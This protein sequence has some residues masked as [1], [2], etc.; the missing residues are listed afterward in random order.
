ME[1]IMDKIKT[2]TKL[3]FR[4][5]KY[6]NLFLMKYQ[7]KSKLW[8]LVTIFLSAG[9]IAYDLIK[10]QSYLFSVLGGGFIVYSLYKFFTLEKTLDQQLINFFRG[11]PV[12]TQTVE[13]DAEEIKVYRSIDPENPIVYNWSYVTAIYEMPQY[14]MLMV[15][16]GSPIIIDRSME[17][18]I[19]G[20]QEALTAIVM[21]KA[22]LKPYKKTEEDIVQ[23]P[24]TYVHEVFPTADAVEV[25][26][27]VEETSEEK[28]EVEEVLVEDVS[29][30]LVEDEI[31]EI[32][33]EE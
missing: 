33:D 15:G 1:E 11:R 13:L 9:I 16:K 7:R 30:D 18:V 4:T 2:L 29:E 24:I 12:N 25:D 5:L 32:E 19:E 23:I 8:I 3:D 27:Q 28:L 22:S 26:N 10:L 6:C 31:K 20:S 14:Y 21:E 17:A